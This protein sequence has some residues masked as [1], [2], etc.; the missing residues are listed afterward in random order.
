[1]FGKPKDN[2]TQSDR[3][4]S[5]VQQLQRTPIATSEALNNGSN[6]YRAFGHREFLPPNGKVWDFCNGRF[7]LNMGHCGVQISCYSG[8]K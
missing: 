5:L 1:M 4:P 3:D 6:T 2:L 8:A 7:F